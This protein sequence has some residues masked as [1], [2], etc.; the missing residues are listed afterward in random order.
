MKNFFKKE[1]KSC[2]PGHNTVLH[3]HSPLQILAE[4]TVS[5]GKSATH[6]QTIRS[7]DN[8]LSQEQQ[9]RSPSPLSN[10]LPPGS[11]SD[12]WGL[13]LVMRFGWGHRAKPYQEQA[14]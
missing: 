12:M 3:I 9:G 2:H 1:K 7:R 14:Q 5:E 6:F 13:Q 10:H 8:S 4:E 11:S